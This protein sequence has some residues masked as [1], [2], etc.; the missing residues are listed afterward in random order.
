MAENPEDAEEEKEKLKEIGNIQSMQIEL[1]EQ[2]KKDEANA[3]SAY[4]LDAISALEEDNTS[5]EGNRTALSP[6]DDSFGDNNTT[7]LSPVESNITNSNAYKR[8]EDEAAALLAEPVTPPAPTP[9]PGED[10]FAGPDAL[11][12]NQTSIG[13]DLGPKIM[14]QMAGVLP[15]DAGVSSLKLIPG[16][17][18]GGSVHGT[19]E[20]TFMSGGMYYRG[21]IDDS[22]EVV[23]LQRS[24]IIDGEIN[25]ESRE[26]LIQR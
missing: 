18:Q 2:M 22:G 24:K 16:R 21:N 1:V 25:R 20:F 15:P 12:A 26:T 4:A 19:R 11:S 7:A 10:P 17:A 8:G 23:L 14:Q 9:V 13:R 5:I 6:T 3:S